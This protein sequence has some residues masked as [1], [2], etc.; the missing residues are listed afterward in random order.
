MP[1]TGHR[2]PKSEYPEPASEDF[3]SLR[4]SSRKEP[5]FMVKEQAGQ[6]VV[7]NPQIPRSFGLM[8]IIFGA[9]MLLVAVGFALSY[10]Y[11]PILQKQFQIPIKE[12]QEK[13]KAERA[14]KIADLKKQEASAKT[15]EEKLALAG[16]R[17]ALEAKVDPD[18]SALEELQ[19]LNAFSDPRLAVYY[20][21]EIAT[22]VILNVIMIIAG[23]GLLGLAEWARRLS[24][25]VSQLKMLRWLAMVVATMVLIM[26]IS[27]ERADKAM[28]AIEGQIKVQGGAAPPFSL[29]AFM[30]WSMMFGA[31]VM[32]F[33]AIVAC[34][35]PALEWWYL[36]RPPARA[37]CMTQPKPDSPETDP[38]WET[39]A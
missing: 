16:E 31:V 29:P 3:L 18:L 8:N 39:T 5:W 28:T 26:P 22:A 34:V 27:M 15:E 36:S 33:T 24:I 11:A 30:R 17:S 14:E 13:Q 10:V 20:I 37:A 23:A 25:R 19:N 4:R 1:R 21:L 12:A 38:L 35:Y 32:V 2:Q 7:P 9:I 6:W